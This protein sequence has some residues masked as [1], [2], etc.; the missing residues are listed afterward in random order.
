[1]DT[2]GFLMMSHMIEPE[3][4]AAQGKLMEATARNAST[5]PTPAAR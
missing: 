1:M 4:L 3:Q 5:W 2:V